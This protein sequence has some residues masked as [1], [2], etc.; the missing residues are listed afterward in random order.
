MPRIMQLGVMK[1]A[2]Q[3]AVKNRRPGEF[4]RARTHPVKFTILY[5]P[6]PPFLRRSCPARPK[7]PAVS[8]RTCRRTFSE[9]KINILSRY[10]CCASYFANYVTGIAA[11]VLV[12][13]VICPSAFAS[14]SGVSHSRPP[15]PPPL[16]PSH[17]PLHCT[18][19]FPSSLPIY[20]RSSRHP[21]C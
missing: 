8:R 4:S 17:P 1:C 5:L 19:P 16:S 7:S 2:S 13:E 3:Y 20:R 15:P 10:R 9:L 11:E 6:L 14:F 18:P 12:K 21:F